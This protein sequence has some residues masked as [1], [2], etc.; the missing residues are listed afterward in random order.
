MHYK[1]QFELHA[2]HGE[3]KLETSTETYVGGFD[4]GFFHGRGK[5]QNVRGFEYDGFFALGQRDGEGRGGDRSCGLV[6]DG[7]WTRGNGVQASALDVEVVDEDAQYVREDPAA[8]AKGAKGKQAAVVSD[9]PEGYAMKVVSGA[10]VP[11]CKVNVVD[12]E[13]NLLPM[14]TGRLL[15]FTLQQPGGD[16]EDPTE[17]AFAGRPAKQ[18]RRGGTVNGVCTIGPKG[19]HSEV[20]LELPELAQGVYTLLIEDVTP[21]LHG[22]R[23]PKLTKEEAADD[24]DAADAPDAANEDEEEEKE[25][26]LEYEDD[27]DCFPLSS[28]LEP[29]RVHLIVSE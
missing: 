28:C 22:R 8:A 16:D 4:A 13:G 3:G 5:M 6:Y 9:V 7:L 29:V 11:H 1:G 21:I 2:F 18:E 27:P 23:P 25:L 17:M 20:L 10:P 24:P 26:E 15:R 12:S 19:G 14:E